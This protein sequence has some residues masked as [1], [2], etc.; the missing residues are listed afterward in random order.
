MYVAQLTITPK[1]TS[2][3][4]AEEIREATIG[5]CASLQKHGQIYG[6][7]VLAWAGKRLQV[8]LTLAGPDAHTVKNHS[9]WGR[10]ELRKLCRLCKTEPKWTMVS[11]AAKRR[12]PA[13]DWRK[14]AA[15]Y[16]YTHLH[17]QTS[18]VRTGS[19]GEPVP[20]Y[21]LPL[22]DPEIEW[23]H[24]WAHRYRAYDL[25]WICSGALEIP[26]YIQTAD[27]NSELSKDGRLI[28][29]RI[30]RGTGRPTY[31]YL[32][33]HYGW[34]DQ[35]RERNRKCPGCGRAWAQQVEASLRW[36]IADFEFRCDR[37]R[38]VSSVGL[39]DSEQR[40]ARIG[41]WKPRTRR[42]D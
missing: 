19:A 6:D 12:R 37:C 22:D 23:I 33:R 9:K 17:D 32:H 40:H 30:E 14:E 42:K 18:P 5:Y 8:T 21:S 25:I 38:L 24:G 11:N 27:P 10:S 36:G 41:E 20:A 15:L 31:Y 29:R 4:A 16:L 34:R 28:C 7:E 2:D 26:A 35:E 13:P 1:A 39:D 3:E